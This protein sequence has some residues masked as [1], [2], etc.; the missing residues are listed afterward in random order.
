MDAFLN[1][2]IIGIWKLVSWLYSD[3]SGKT[4]YFFGEHI[5]GIIM[6]TADGYVSTHLLKQDRPLFASDDLDGFT[7]IEAKQALSGYLGYYGKYYEEKPGELVH[8][9]EGCSSPHWTNKQAIR[10]AEVKDDILTLTT[11]SITTRNGSMVFHVNWKR[12]TVW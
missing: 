7:A 3:E 11:P 10:Y 4:G 12:V 2:R 9:I 1:E 8:I 5:M 6:Y